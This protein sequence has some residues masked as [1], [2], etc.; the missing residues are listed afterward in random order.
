MNL[1]VGKIISK[2]ILFCLMCLD[3]IN[4]KAS[5]NAYKRG[6]NA[7]NIV[8]SQVKEG[9]QDLNMK[10]DRDLFKL[11]M[12]NQLNCW[13]SRPNV[14]KSDDERKF[15]FSSINETSSSY[16]HRLQNSN[17]EIAPNDKNIK[18]KWYLYKGDDL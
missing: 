14:L 15:V 4:V 10:R 3:T 1:T 18:G 17:V 5:K 16:L 2:K 8:T 13:K 12:Q 9:I 7:G 11:T 6:V